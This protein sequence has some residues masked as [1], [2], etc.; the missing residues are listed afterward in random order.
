MHVRLSHENIKGFTRAVVF[1]CF[2]KPVI[3]GGLFEFFFSMTIDSHYFLI[4]DEI[5]S[6]NNVGT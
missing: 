4:S 5:P 1:Y 6:A 2:P 3:E